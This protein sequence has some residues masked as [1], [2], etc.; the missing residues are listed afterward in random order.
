[1]K[2]SKLYSNINYNIKYLILI[3]YKIVNNILEI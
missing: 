2:I 3:F 1:M